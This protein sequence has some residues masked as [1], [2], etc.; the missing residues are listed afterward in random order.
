MPGNEASHAVRLRSGRKARNGAEDEQL[1]A[2][3]Y[4]HNGMNVLIWLNTA[5]YRVCIVLRVH[6]RK[7]EAAG[8]SPSPD[9]ETMASHDAGVVYFTKYLSVLFQLTYLD[10][11]CGECNGTAHACVNSGYQALFSPIT[12]RQGTR[13]FWPLPC[14]CS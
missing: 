10:E 11:L 14:L 9:F 13:L 5:R 6:F 1:T 2:I 7:A 3:Q 4:V 12:K 8:V